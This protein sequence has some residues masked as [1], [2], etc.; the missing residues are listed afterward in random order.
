MVNTGNIIVTER[1]ENPLSPTYNTTRTRTYQDLRRCPQPTPVMNFKWAYSITGDPDH[2]IE[3]E[4]I[5]DYTLGPT[6]RVWNLVKVV[7]GD[8][9]HQVEAGTFQGIT[10][11]TE[12]VVSPNTYLSEECFAGC[13]GLRSLTLYNGRTSIS[14]DV[15]AGCT[16]LA[17]VILPESMQ[18]I[19]YRA[20]RG[21]S[22]L[23]SITCLAPTPPTLEYRYA[24]CDVFDDTND[25][26]IYVPT[27]SVNAYKTASGW[28]EY[29]S[30]IQALPS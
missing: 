26:P 8:C 5:S 14:N 15:F 10:T 17:E 18:R 27:E 7:L 21:C 12:V 3:Q 1:D 29:A 2:L 16:R 30:R 20:F 4:C 19:G 6:E 13:S 28:D 25:C 22:G 23:T 11:I 24:I 9:C